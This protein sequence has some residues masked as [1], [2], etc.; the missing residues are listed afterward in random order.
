MLL[1]RF[2]DGKDARGALHRRDHPRTPT[3]VARERHLGATQGDA[4][5]YV[6]PASKQRGG[7]ALRICEMGVDDAAAGLTLEP[8]QQRQTRESHAQPIEPFEGSGY[9]EEPRASDL[10]VLLH[11]HRRCRRPEMRPPTTQQ[12]LKRKPRNGGDDD[13]WKQS[14]DA[15]HAF[16]NEEARRRLPRMRK[17]RA[18]DDDPG[19]RLGHRSLPFH[20]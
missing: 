9:R 13:Q 10:D 15:K 12:A 2:R 19:F 20:P 17:E 3:W 18:Q 5:G 11:L 4:Y 1:E 7:I 16:A 14:S 8:Q 6:Q